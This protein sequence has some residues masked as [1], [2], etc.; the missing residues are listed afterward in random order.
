MS[1]WTIDKEIEFFRASLHNFS[2]PEQ[3]FY[4]LQ[5]E[6]FVYVPKGYSAE[7]QTINSRNSLIG[8][9]TETWCKSIFDSIANNLNLYAVN[10]VIC[11]EL[12]LTSS[13]PA[14]MAFCTT[15]AIQQDPQDIKL[16]F[17]IKMS[18]ISNYKYTKPRKIEWIGDYN[19]HKGNPSL[20]RSD[21]MLKAIGKAI[22]VRVSCLDS[23][24]IPI[25]V[26][27][28][29]PIT[30]HYI[31]KVDFLKK[32]GVIQGFLSL[33][34]DPTTTE[35][36]K[37]TPERGFITVT[38]SRE[39]LPLCR[40]LIDTD[41][42]YFSSMMPKDRIGEIIRI[43]NQEETDIGKAEKFLQLIRG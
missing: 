19:R 42:S 43:A 1:L 39:L 29:S 32:S 14:D 36:I 15:N 17:E 3:L 25:V 2:T 8:Q 16:L 34:P 31:H 21:S 30:Y 9:Y 22:N 33:Y 35:F 4:F 6:Y 18:I 24:K 10:G 23:T 26:I 40:S 13:S 7:G 11:E 12:G 37:E 38:D 20:L 28:N 27:G 41:M 5:N